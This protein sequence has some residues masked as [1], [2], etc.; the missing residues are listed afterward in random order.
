MIGGMRSLTDNTAFFN[1][2]TQ[3]LK[4]AIIKIGGT[5]ISTAILTN[6]RKFY[7][8]NYGIQKI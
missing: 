4:D 2:A 3:A 6:L 7:S 1:V 8:V 5:T